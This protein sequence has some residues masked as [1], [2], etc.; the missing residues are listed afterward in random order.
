MAN[1]SPAFPHPEKPCISHK[2]PD[3]EQG[4]FMPGLTSGVRR[5][6][7]GHHSHPRAPPSEACRMSFVSFPCLCS[8]ITLDLSLSHFPYGQA[9]GLWDESK[10]PLLLTQ[11]QQ[12]VYKPWQSKEGCGPFAGEA[13]A[14]CGCRIPTTPL[15]LPPV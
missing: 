6:R 8:H 13:D 12:I 14:S 2:H 4:S 11:L 10:K 15:S 1:M 5:G 7:D 9:T 3:G